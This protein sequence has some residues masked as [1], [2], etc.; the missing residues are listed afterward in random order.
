MIEVVR[1]YVLPAAFALLPEKWNT[2]EATALLLAIGLQES[3]FEH[4]RQLGG[5]ARGFWQFER[6]GVRGVMQHEA[7]LDDIDRAVNALR[8]SPTADVVDLHGALEH[9]DVLAACFARALLW[10]LPYALPAP[11]APAHGWDCYRNAWRPGKPHRETW[12]A[13]FARAWA[14]TI[15]TT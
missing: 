1:D 4:R 10:T 2:P 6:A 12:D 8:Y 5:P 14:L 9:N 3:R 15:G 13:H 11:D 7:V